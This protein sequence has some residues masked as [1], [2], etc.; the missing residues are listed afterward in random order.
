MKLIAKLLDLL[1]NKARDLTFRN[2]AL[3]SRVIGVLRRQ[4]PQ[5]CADKLDVPVR[6]SHVGVTRIELARE[7]C[8]MVKMLR[9]ILDMLAG[10]L[11]TSTASSAVL[12]VVRLAPIV[13]G[14]VPFA[15]RS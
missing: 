3:Q 11:T 4:A 15:E 14:R 12:V 1:C 9:V 8:V 5:K 6:N 10:I 2:S 13:A 7:A